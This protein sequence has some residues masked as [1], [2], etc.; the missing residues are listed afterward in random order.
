MRV[1]LFICTK[2]LQSLFFNFMEI[3]QKKRPTIA[4]FCLLC[5]VGIVFFLSVCQN[6]LKSCENPCIC[7]VTKG[8]EVLWQLSDSTTIQVLAPPSENCLV[9][10]VSEHVAGPAV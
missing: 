10:S 2:K 1:D 4:A 6:A 8:K 7:D 3:P 5:R 9:L